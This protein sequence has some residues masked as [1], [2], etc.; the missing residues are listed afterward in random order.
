MYMYM[1]VERCKRN[2]HVHVA[3]LKR[4]QS[5]VHVRGNS[6]FRGTYLGRSIGLVFLADVE[7][8]LMHGLCQLVLAL[9]LVQHGQRVDL[10]SHQ[11]VVVTKRTLEDLK[12]LQM[13]TT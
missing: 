12:C 4:F 7:C 8:A 13:Y 11:I 10:A 1:Y 5:Q 2:I 9:A 6:S 3:V